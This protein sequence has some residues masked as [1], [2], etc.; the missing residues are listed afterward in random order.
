MAQISVDNNG[1]TQ[2]VDDSGILFKNIDMANGTV[3]QTDGTK[4][5][6]KNSMFLPINAELGRIGGRDSRKFINAVDIDWN[7]AQMTNGDGTTNAETKTLNTS[8]DLL[9]LINDQQE[10]IYILSS[11]VVGQSEAIADLYQ[12]LSA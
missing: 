10:Q 4:W 6:A 2:Y 8:G 3:S 7:G 1:I 5:T 9:K 11:V 12:R